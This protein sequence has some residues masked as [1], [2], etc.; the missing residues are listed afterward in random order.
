MAPASASAA[1]RSGHLDRTYGE[2]GVAMTKFGLAGEGPTVSLG[3]GPDGSAVIADES[4]GLIVRF[5]PGGSPDTRFGRGGRLVTAPGRG[6]VGGGDRRF[7]PGPVAVDGAGRI[8]AFGSISDLGKAAEGS[9]GQ[10]VS[11]TTA[12]VLRF[13]SAGNLD[14]SFG[15]GKGFFEGDL[16]IPAEPSTGIARVG[17]LAGG[18]DSKNRPL[19]VGSTLVLGGG[20]CQGH[21]GSVPQAQEVA[22]LTEAGQ[23]DPAFGDGEGVSPLADPGASPFLALDAADQ[24]TVGTRIS[25]GTC[26]LGTAVSSLAEDGE[27]LAGSGPDGGRIYKRLGLSLVEPSGATILSRQYA[28]TLQVVRVGVEGM[29]DQG[30]GTD[31]LAVVDL[32]V[33]R[34]LHLRPAAVDPQ[35][36]IMLVGFVGSPFS[37]PVKGQPRRSSFVVGRLLPDGKLDRTFGNRGWIFTRFPEPL[38]AISARAT[39]DPQGRLLVGGIVTKPKHPVGAFAVA[40]YLL[41]R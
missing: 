32:T 4:A 40:R 14:K 30:F 26:R 28:R 31:G 9:E 3:A 8:L 23:L 5:G 6:F 13:T 15:E 17:V 1:G 37:E 7:N 11:P 33:E 10:K 12:A 38:E 39:L 36:R 24:P 18:V 19:L 27:P 35:G 21:S 41:G 20:G 25:L 2:A 34:G 29:R 16:G 22:R